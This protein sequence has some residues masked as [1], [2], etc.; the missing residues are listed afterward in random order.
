MKEPGFSVKEIVGMLKE[1]E[2]GILVSEI[3]RNH[4]II[5]GAF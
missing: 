3:F 4:G 1:L 5:Q 2:G